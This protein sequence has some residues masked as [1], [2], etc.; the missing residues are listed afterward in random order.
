MYKKEKYFLFAKYILI[1]RFENKN[2]IIEVIII[3][4]VCFLLE[5]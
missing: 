5:T 2:E 3:S 1:F 4:Q